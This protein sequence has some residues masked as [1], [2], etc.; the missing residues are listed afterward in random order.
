[1]PV[2]KLKVEAN[3]KTQDVLIAMTPDE[4]N[5][6]VFVRDWEQRETELARESLKKPVPK[7][8]L[9]KQDVKEVVKEHKDFKQ[10]QVRRNTSNRYFSGDYTS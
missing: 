2:K 1:M 4:A 5:D 6:R 7:S 3:G 9:S 8:N 10:A